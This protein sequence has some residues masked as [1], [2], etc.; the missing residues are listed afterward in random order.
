MK[1]PSGHLG[2]EAG[3][4]RLCGVQPDVT[5]MLKRVFPRI[6]AVTLEDEHHFPDT[7][8]IARELEWFLSRYPADMREEDRSYLT[9]RA[10]Q[11]LESQS[12]IQAIMER[13]WKPTLSVAR[14]FRDGYSLR[15]YQH[16]AA[17]LALT[18]KG[19]LLADD[20]GLGKTYSA[21]GTICAAGAGPAAVVVPAHLQPQWM[22]KT[23]E[24]TTLRCHAITGT[25]PYDLPDADVYVFRYSQLAGWS[26]TFE[27]Y[28]FPVVVW[29]EVH[30]LRHGTNTL[31]GEAAAKLGQHAEVRL[32]LSA[33]PIFNYGDEAWA[34]INLIDP[35]LLGEKDEFRR[36][37]RVD[38][39]GRVPDAHA[40]GAYLHR[41][42]A[43]LRRTKKDVGQEMPPINTLVETI[44][45]DAKAVAKIEELARTLARR[46]VYGSWR[47]SG[48]AGRELDMLVRQAT[49]VGKAPYIAAYI[50][51]IAAAGTPVVVGAWHRAVYD[52][53]LSSLADLSPVLY[54]G[55]ETTA[56]K[57]R[58]AQAFINGETNVMLV[59]LRAGAGLDGLQYRCSTVIHAELDFSPAVHQ[60]LTGRVDRD[61]QQEPVT[62]IYLTC[63]D[64]SDPV[65]TDLLGLKASQ[66]HGIVEPGRELSP[67]HTDES[68]IK[69]LA[70]RFLSGD[71]VSAIRQQA[72]QANEPEIESTQR[73]PEQL[74]LEALEP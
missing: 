70:M 52:I 25:R 3:K 73:A 58:S 2:I 55:S 51:M 10:A 53:L 36:E 33:T 21:L 45:S 72:S 19:V 13:G 27:A 32:G 34:L 65:L 12:R 71:E 38:P 15:A 56:Q 41:T 35:G 60:Q 44:P 47:E 40:L 50:R 37:W 9:Q 69:A 48:E 63:A 68:R 57:H 16:L 61:G 4:W 24:I 1:F 46:V 23:A 67:R 31:K 22:E 66:A 28:R 17:E 39:S 29:D 49:G 62:S 18:R 64:G 54:T 5:I 20:I 6:K 8:P 11:H 43:M 14:R 7:P 74:S 30:D 59:S 26:D 42:G